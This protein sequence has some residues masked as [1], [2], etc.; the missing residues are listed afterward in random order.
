MEAAAILA[1]IEGALTILEKV[2]PELEAAVQSGDITKEQQG[3]VYS[4]AGNL[5]PGGTA[6]SGPEWKP[7][8]K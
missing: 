1:I 7:S 5:R 8:N 4:R 2:A 6:F 3:A